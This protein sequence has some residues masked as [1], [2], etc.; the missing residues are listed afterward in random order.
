[1][2]RVVFFAYGVACYVV[3]LCTIVY[4]VGFVGNLLVPKSIDAVAQG[5]LDRAVLIDLLLLGLFAVQHSLMARRGF[6][7]WWSRL[8]PQPIERSTYVL[9][10]CL[11][12]ILL[13]WQWRPLGGVIWDVR[14]LAGRAV[15]H[16][17]AGGGWILAFAGTF[18]IDHFGLFGLRQVW[19]HLRGESYDSPGF[20]TPGPYRYV[21]HPLYT[22]WLVAVWAAP[23]MTVTHLLF[24]IATTCYILIGI[25]FEERDL[26]RSHVGYADYRRRVPML[27]PRLHRQAAGQKPRSER[28]AV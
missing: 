2:S 7:A 26:L 12:L 8:V 22:G 13:F 1:M 23:T 24:G 16:A 14:P 4:A 5:S 9:F 18:A 20:A 10:S 3:F 11:V 15:L 19:L 25:R 6:K 27:V 28:G 17:L 21:R